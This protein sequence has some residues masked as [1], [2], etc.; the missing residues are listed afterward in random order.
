MKI[1]K[2]AAVVAAAA[3][4]AVAAP[5]TGVLPDMLSVTASAAS[6]DPEPKP[7]KYKVG[8]VFAFAMNPETGETFGEATDVMAAHE[9]SSKEF[10]NGAVYC[11]RILD[12]ETISVSTYCMGNDFIH[13]GKEITIPSQIGGYT[14]T[15]IG[16]ECVGGFSSITIPDTVKTINQA[17]F[18]FNFYLEEVNFGTNSQL[19]F[20]DQWA[21][22]DCRSLKSIA[23]PASVE[24]IA[25]GAFGNTD[26]EFSSALIGKDFTNVYSLASVNF[27]EGSKLKLIDQWAF[28]RQK[29]LKSITLP[30]SLEKIGSG[31]F[32]NCSGLTE[33]TVPANVDEIGSSAFSCTGSNIMNIS[34]IEV[35]PDNK[36]YK[37]VDGILFSK[38]GK[39]IVRYPAARSGSYT[40]PADVNTLS[41]GAFAHS[42]KLTSVTIPEGVTDIPENAFTYCTSLAE[43]KLPS[44]LKTIAKWGFEATA[45]TAIDIPESVTSIDAHAFDSSP[46]KTISGKTGSYAETY[47]KENG[48]KFNG[49]SSDM[50]SDPDKDKPTTF[51]DNSGEK[52]ADVQVI[53]K[54]NVIPKEA[55]FSVRLDDSSTAERVAYNCYFTYNGAEYE[56]TETVTV[57][58][59]VPVAMRDIADTLKVYHLQDGKYVNM[60]AKVEGGYLVFDTDHFSVYVITAEDLGDKSG[61]GNNSGSENPGKNPVTGIAGGMFGIMAIAGAF[62]I[63]SRKRR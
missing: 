3:V 55:H 26:N 2:I 35:D 9:I 10:G 19:K 48:Y 5:M 60:S 38:D 54:P 30:D 42:T 31:A 12:D 7:V 23:I 53:A 59:P 32:I 29:A 16:S 62:V 57:R 11:C 51:T 63:V 28:Q 1:K 58:I 40:I 33:I 21:F 47:A 50:P 13:N 27:A 43:V 46:L 15:E 61:S 56:P 45:L 37:S 44:S 22:Q 18:A 6:P 39:N 36:Y 14:V 52:A 24:T 41:D 34:K 8:D 20:I 25:T 4:L 49:G 17:A